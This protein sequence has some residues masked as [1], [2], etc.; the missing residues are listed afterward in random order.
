M[1][2]MAPAQDAT[3][4][5]RRGF[6]EKDPQITQMTQIVPGVPLTSAFREIP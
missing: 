6:E 1:T 5:V 3:I 4:A 2:Q